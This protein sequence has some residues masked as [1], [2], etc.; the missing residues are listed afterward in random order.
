M[1]AIVLSAGQGRRLLPLTDQDPKCLLA[2]D[3]PHTIL[4]LQ[5]RALSRCGIR[6]VTVMLG[7][8]AD[9]VERFLASTRIPN[10]RVETLYNPFFASSDNLATCWLAR[11]AMTGDFVLLNGDTLFEDRVLE[12]LLASPPAPITV[13]IDHKDHYDDDDMKVS[14]D[15]N[16]RLLAIGKRLPPETVGGE[17]IGLLCFRGTGVKIFRDALERVIRQPDG[18]KAWYLSVVN[19]LAGRIAVATT[20]IDGLWW[21]EVD[22]PADLERARA[23]FAATPQIQKRVAAGR[24]RGGGGR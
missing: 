12:R 6:Q 3:G 13:T 9:R 21:R 1:K 5:L 8:G 4:E 10:L 17:S 20:S 18:L 24:A 2:V 19:D 14:I 16:G 23:S 7:F 22:S 15:A 11:V